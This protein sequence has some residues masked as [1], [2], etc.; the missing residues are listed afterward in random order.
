M[1]ILIVGNGGREHAIAWKIS[2]SPSFDSSRDRLFCTYPNPGIADICEKTEIKPDNIIELL[3]FAKSHDIDFTVVGPEIPLSLGI[4]DEFGKNRLKI[5]GPSKAAAELETSKIYAK[6]FMAANEIP[7]AKYKIFNESNYP[8]ATEFLNIISYPAVIKADGLAAGKGVYIAKNK[9][10]ALNFIDEITKVKIFG[11]SGE[12]FIIEEYLDGF[13]LSVFAV[14]DG[15]NYVILPTAQDH[16]KIG[17][18][19]TGK[20]TGGMGS[21]SPADSLID[22]NTFVKIRS[23]IIEPTLYGMAKTGREY[24]GCLYCGLMLTKTEEGYEPFVIEYNCRFGDPEAQ[25]VLP[26]IKSDFLQLLIASAEN[27][28]SG[29]NLE[30]EKLFAGCVVAASKGYPDNY[31][32]GKEIKGLG[33]N[34]DNSV[35]FHAGTK[36]SEDGKTVITSGGR[37]LNITGLS[38]LS[39]DDALKNAYDKIGQINFDKMYYRRD[40]GYKFSDNTGK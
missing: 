3:E 20:N 32:T 9:E 17:E 34:T 33:K 31:E 14:T 15:K 11:S 36:Y 10:D 39:I 1:K 30:T 2:N 38:E 29:Y 19:D 8:S 21:Y 35:V 40:I 7:T 28:I 37:V 18:G 13:E 4:A 26:L 24:K 23:K 16:K 27:K 5:F 12:K 22:E 6:E 25:S